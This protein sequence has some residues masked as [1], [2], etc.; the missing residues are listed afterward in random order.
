MP[1]RRRRIPTD[2]VTATVENLSHE[3]RG[4]THVDGKTVFIHNAL[5]GEKVEFKYTY[6]SRSHDEAKMT[7]IIAPSDDR[8]SPACRH[9]EFCGGCQMQHMSMEK[10]IEHKQNILLEQ[11][12]H[13]GKT[14][15]KKVINPVTAQELGYRRKAR[16]GVR[17]IP[18]KERVLVGFR[19]RNGRY[20]ADLKQCVVLHPELGEKLEILGKLIEQLSC[21]Q[22]VPQLET[23]VGENKTA[24]ILRHMVE[25]TPEDK[26]ILINFGKEHQI[27]IYSQPNKPLPMEKLYS[28]S[29]ELLN[30]Q[31]DNHNITMHF[32]PSDF[33][34]VNNEINQKMIDLALDL[35]D[36]KPEDKVLD[37]FCGIGNFSLPIARYAKEVTGVE[38]SESAVKRA[39]ENAEKNNLSNTKFYAAN[40]FEDNSE[41][42]WFNQKYNKILI[43]PARSGAEEIANIIEKFDAEIIVYV[44]C[45][46][47]TLA[48]D[49]GVLV[50]NKNYT[51]QKAGIMNMFPHTAHVESIALF[52]KK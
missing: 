13:F 34:Q 38:L 6:C 23:A 25:L 42:E 26:Q 40:L 45:N 15:P 47:A 1:R 51:L 8:V 50:N 27:E 11:L 21:Y 44:S 29:D 24:I 46:P 2:I 14:S 9:Y 36:L 4:V 17:H 20:I 28:L 43:D 33:T 18:K 31:L 35:L 30:Y 12:K 22:H 48:R 49:A 16:I 19:E 37:L 39:E 7:T 5:P 32:Q 10:Q 52:T 3:G 41:Q